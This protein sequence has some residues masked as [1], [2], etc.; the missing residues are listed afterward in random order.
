V[1][2]NLLKVTVLDIVVIITVTSELLS[3]G[4]GED[5]A[6]TVFDA[7]VVLVGTDKLICY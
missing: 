6:S 2:E 3:I 5:I 1:L 4:K 7:Q